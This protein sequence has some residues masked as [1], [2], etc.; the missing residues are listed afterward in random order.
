LRY[1]QCATAT[2]KSPALDLAHVPTFRS[3]PGPRS[4]RRC[5]QPG[6]WR[7]HIAGKP[8]ARSTFCPPHRSRDRG[9]SFIFNQLF[10]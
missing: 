4:L 3:E 2:Q 9:P 10:A 8:L 6:L 7:T 5:R 1:E